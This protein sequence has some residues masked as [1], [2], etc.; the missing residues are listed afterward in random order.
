MYPANPLSTMVAKATATETRSS[1]LG[2]SVMGKRELNRQKT[3]QKTAKGRK[4][5]LNYRR[6][7]YM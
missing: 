6:S 4:M 7:V 3:T 1:V 2:V 5:A